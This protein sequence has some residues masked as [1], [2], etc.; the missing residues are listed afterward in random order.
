MHAVLDAAQA[1]RQISISVRLHGVSV[2]LMPRKTI[3][4]ETLTDIDDRWQEAFDK[5]GLERSTDELELLV[6]RV[7]L[8][9][10]D[11]RSSRIGTI[12]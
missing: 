11:A 8:M 6:F 7:A 5:I 2:G 12:E 3:R 1:F 9:T 10:L 4:D